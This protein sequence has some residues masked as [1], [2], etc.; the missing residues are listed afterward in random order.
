M[1]RISWIN[2][3]VQWICIVTAALALASCGGGSGSTTGA[4]DPPPT[5][6][7]VTTTP[8]AQTGVSSVELSP[9]MDNVN[10][11]ATSQ[12][13][14][15]LKDAA[16]A[17]L[18]GRVTS[19]TS[20][21]A[22]SVS[23]SATGVVTGLTTGSATITATSEGKSANALITV[24]SLGDGRRHRRRLA[25]LHPQHPGLCLPRAQCRDG[26]PRHHPA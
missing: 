10:P 17:V 1:R 16:G 3:G 20:S 5:A 4:T 22:A 6:P 13:T 21:N 18:S 24:P 12:L 2:S 19:W 15:T 9:T 26:G 8:P 23:V 14:A 7:P 25:D 11:G